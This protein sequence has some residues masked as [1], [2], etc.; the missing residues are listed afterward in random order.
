M[1]VGK[2]NGN[3]G[4]SKEEAIESMTKTIPR[5]FLNINV[6]IQQQSKLKI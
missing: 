1:S 2:L 4:P 5:T 3:E 6:R